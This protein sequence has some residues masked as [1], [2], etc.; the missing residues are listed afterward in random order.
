MSYIKESRNT[1]TV[2]VAE[3]EDNDAEAAD[4]VNPDVGG[5]VT[6]I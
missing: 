4:Y 5:H 3:F 6:Q 2:F 1:S